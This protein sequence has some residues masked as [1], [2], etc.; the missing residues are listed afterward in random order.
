MEREWR[1]MTC[2]R[3]F[4]NPSMEEQ[5]TAILK[6]VKEVFAV[7]GIKDPPD[8]LMQY[9][10]DQ[11]LANTLSYEQVKQEAIKLGS[12]RTEIEKTENTP[13]LQELNQEKQSENE[14]KAKIAEYVDQL[15]D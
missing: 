5:R 8:H 1:G 2:V 10:T 12:K 9:Y 13:Q 3:H 11:I 14:R 7:V 4:V 6:W 15:C